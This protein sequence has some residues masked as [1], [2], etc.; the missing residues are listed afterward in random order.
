[1]SL[2]VGVER[3]E[4]LVLPRLAATLA[5]MKAAGVPDPVNALRRLQGGSDESELAQYA[6]VF[7][8]CRGVFTYAGN[9]QILEQAMRQAVD[10]AASVVI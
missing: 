1:M 3:L 5:E 10:L 2:S 7:D 8:T 9:E 4:V 6:K